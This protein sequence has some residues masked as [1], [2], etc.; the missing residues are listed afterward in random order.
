M[1]LFNTLKFG[2]TAIICLIG[3][4]NAAQSPDDTSVLVA[5]TIVAPYEMTFEDRMI[6][7]EITEKEVNAS[8]EEM[9]RFTNVNI[10]IEYIENYVY[11]G[12]TIQLTGKSKTIQKAWKSYVRDQNNI[13]LKSKKF[14]SLFDK[15]T[16][17]WKAEKIQ[18]TNVS[19]NVGD[20]LTVFRTQDG[21]TKMTV[22]YRLGYNTAINPANFGTEFERLKTYVAQFG[23]DNFIQY[24]EGNLKD[25]NKNI[26]QVQKELNS[27]EKHLV[28]LE[29]RER[30]MAKKGE[31]AEY[32]QQSMAVQQLLIVSLEQEMAH[33][34]NLILEYKIH[35]SK[36]RIKKAGNA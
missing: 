5:D 36:L 15:K 18:L 23:D 28:H 27:E 35:R 6:L 8:A 13:R 20:V 34:E 32:I 22:V 4:T 33:Y 26:S 7:E 2:T 14:K 3:F 24:Y 31:N 17:Y 9:V 29:K 25:L 30:K 12:V 1:K 21:T 10:E 11:T 16:H 19:S